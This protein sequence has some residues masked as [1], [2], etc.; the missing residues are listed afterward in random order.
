MF[1]YILSDTYF[2]S[3]Y[4]IKTEFTRILESI[5]KE[6]ALSKEVWIPFKMAVLLTCVLQ[7]QLLLHFEW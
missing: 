2:S 5:A 3:S 1:M 7:I 6:K 4:F